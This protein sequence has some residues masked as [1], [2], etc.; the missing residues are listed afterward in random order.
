MNNMKAIRPLRIAII[1]D[2][3]YPDSGGIARS[4]E[5]QIGELV[6]AGHEV[7]LFAPKHFF[8]PP[9]NCRW[10]TLDSGRIPGSESYFCTLKFGPVVAKNIAGRHKFDIIHSQNERG[11]IFLASRVAQTTNTPHVHTFHTNYTSIYRTSPISALIGSFMYL[12]LITHIARRVRP[13]RPKIPVKAPARSEIIESALQSPFD[14]KNMARLA[15][16][17]DVS[18]SPSEYI[19]RNVINISDGTLA[20][21]VF[22]V[23]NGISAAFIEARRKRPEGDKVRFLSCSRLSIEKRVDVII[24]AY[25][26]LDNPNTELYIIGTG[27]QEKQLK[28]LA[29]KAVRRGKVVFIGHYG[30]VEKLARE[31]ADSDVFVMASYRFDTQGMVLGE[32]AAAGVPILYC[33]DQLRVGVSPENALLAEPSVD[34]LRAGMQELLD[35]PP[36]RRAMAQASKQIGKQL[37]GEAMGRKFVRIYE[38]AIENKHSAAKAAEIITSLAP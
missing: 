38:Q 18:T 11:A 34:G 6:R 27:A 35:S 1:T 24:K 22:T 32:A 14:W 33:D 20:D 10:E 26:A 8:T 12:Y 25:A 23:P 37:T 31:Y 5:L 29:E 28:A 30:D 15:N 7:T 9:G 19:V 13:G 17:A 21:R 36:R 2:D 4:V 16:F 3:F